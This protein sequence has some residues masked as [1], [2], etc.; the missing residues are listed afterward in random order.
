MKNYFTVSM[1]PKLTTQLRTMCDDLDRIYASDATPELKQE[2]A[3][4]SI[5]AWLDDPL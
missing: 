1:I 2:R 5:A 3:D 4:R